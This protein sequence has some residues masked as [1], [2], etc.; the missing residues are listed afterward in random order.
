MLKTQTKLL[1]VSAPIKIS[2]VNYTNTIPFVYGLNNF[3]DPAEIDLQLDIPSVCAEKV[4]GKKVD[5][6]LIPAATISKVQGG[7]IISDFCIGADNKVDSVMLYSDVPLNEIR[8]ILLDYQSRTSVELVKILCRE[9]WKIQP[10]FINAKE[11]FE[12]EITGTTAGV[13]IGDRTFSIRSKYA[14]KFDLAENWN[15]LTGLP[16]VFACWVSCS[17]LTETFT[18]KFNEALAFGLSHID[19]AVE[20][21]P[22]KLLAADEA[23]FYLTERISYRLTSEKKKGLDLFLEKLSA[24]GTH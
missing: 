8:S 22:I 21:S 10:E 14:W 1:R 19:S 13:I 12:N 3:F 15:K 7:K 5:L 11:G 24:A 4:I 16:F 18:K 6:G 2:I 9:L 20:K 17:A 23:L